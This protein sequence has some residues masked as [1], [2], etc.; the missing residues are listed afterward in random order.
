MLRF[1]ACAPVPCPRRA[2]THQGTTACCQRVAVL[3]RT[4]FAR[5]AGSCA[6]LT[7]LPWAAGATPGPCRGS[8]GTVQQ[9]FTP[10]GFA[11]LHGGP[12]G[13]AGASWRF[14]TAGP[15]LRGNRC[16][17]PG[18]V[19]AVAWPGRCWGVRSRDPAPLPSPPPVPCSAGWQS[20]AVLG[21][22]CPWASAARICS[23]GRVGA[24]P[25]RPPTT[26]CPSPGSWPAH[27]TNAHV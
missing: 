17:S 7:Y 14:G 24:A 26:S 2:A 11:V 22:A 16:R 21:T 27:L 15:D 1:T 25:R 9:L 10:P 12:S 20:S 19:G 13:W 3:R 18:A 8:Q 23:P 5:A 4:G 6:T